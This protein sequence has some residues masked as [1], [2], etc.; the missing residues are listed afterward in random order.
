MGK[1]ILFIASIE[2][3]FL[4]FHQPVMRWL[5]E[6]GYE[7]HTAARGN[8]H[9]PYA[10]VQH[11]IDFVRQ[12]FKLGNIY[13]YFQLKRLIGSN[14]FEVVHCH[15]A[16]AGVLARLVFYFNGRCNKVMYT[17]HGFH[18]FKGGPFH[19]W[20]L[21]YPVEKLLS[22][23][24]DYLITINEED[25]QLA[26]QNFASGNVFKIPG[27][28]FSTDR[29]F[30]PSLEEKREARYN[31]NIP[32]SAFVITYA[33]EFIHRKNHLFII[34][35]TVALKGIIPNL[36]VHFLGKGELLEQMKSKVAKL[37]LSDTCF[38]YGF[39]EELPKFLFSSDLAISTSM[40]EG[41]GLNVAE[42]MACGLPVV[43]SNN[44]GHRELV[45][46]GR[47]G[48]LFDLANAKDMIGYIKEISVDS[49]L[50]SKLSANAIIDSKAFAL[51]ES[52][53]KLKGIYSLVI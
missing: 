44:R 5:Q 20:L 9:I 23:C 37:G 15:T 16:V 3:H 18:F 21:Y 22:K 40:Q 7:V 14:Q 51:E 42:A 8:E 6:Q 1:R 36:R 47:N 2:K 11:K 33:A 27:M 46:H 49:Y 17:A 35:N 19:Y 31:L 30:L 24:V 38:F 10:D 48:F 41:L 13:A 53:L 45:R 4:R 32:E 39:T 50:Y 29:Y 43:V 28:G 25:Y 52:M 26:R 34:E 12:P